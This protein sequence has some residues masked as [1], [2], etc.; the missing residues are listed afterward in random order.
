MDVVAAEDLATPPC[1]D[2]NAAL[3]LPRSTRTTRCA[4]LTTEAEA[5][6]TGA[7][8]RAYQRPKGSRETTAIAA[9]SRVR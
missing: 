7:A 6:V 1:Q 4:L 9:N 2:P 5:G 3:S 8:A